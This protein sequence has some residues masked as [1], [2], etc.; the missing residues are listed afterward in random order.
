MEWLVDNCHCFASCCWGKTWRRF[1]LPKLRKCCCCC[2]LLL[3]VVWWLVVVVIGNELGTYNCQHSLGMVKHWQIKLFQPHIDAKS[4]KMAWTL[5]RLGEGQEQTPKMCW[6]FCSSTILVWITT[7]T[8]LFL[9]S[10]PH[11]LLC[12]KSKFSS[13]FVCLLIVLLI[14]GL[15]IHILLVVVVGCCCCCCCCSAVKTQ[16]LHGGQLHNQQLNSHKPQSDKKRGLV[17]AL[18]VLDNLP[19]N[20]VTLSLSQLPVAPFPKSLSFVLPFCANFL[21]YFFVLFFVLLF[22]FFASLRSFASKT[23]KTEQKTNEI[24]KTWQQN[25][26]WLEKQWRFIVGHQNCPGKTK[27]QQK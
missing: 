3:F 24:K 26:N 22:V 14:C 13:L 7:V 2:L 4:K 6:I 21:C 19:H 15:L 23:T 11:L 5:L 17:I 12:K 20:K 27:T 8:T 18:E 9:K 16:E 25:D 1:E 10:V